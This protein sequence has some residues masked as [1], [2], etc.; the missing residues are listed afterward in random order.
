M[1]L[2]GLTG[3][4]RSHGYFCIGLG[5]LLWLICY[6]TTWRYERSIPLIIGMLV[7]GLYSVIWPHEDE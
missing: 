4:K 6:T 1:K 3:M 5:G 2:K 7:V